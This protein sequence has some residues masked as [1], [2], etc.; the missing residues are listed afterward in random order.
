MATSNPVVSIMAGQKK[1]DCTIVCRQL[2]YCDTQF[3]GLFED[4][5]TRKSD[6]ES[7]VYVVVVRSAPGIWNSKSEA[8]FDR[9]EHAHEAA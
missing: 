9:T 6:L 7:P 4:E 3:V 8:Y 1:V 2:S 5:Q